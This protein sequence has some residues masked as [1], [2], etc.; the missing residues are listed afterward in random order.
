MRK[1]NNIEARGGMTRGVVT[2]WTRNPLHNKAIG[3]LQGYCLERSL[4]IFTII[5]FI[6][7]L[8]VL[9]PFYIVF[10]LWHKVIAETFT[11][12]LVSS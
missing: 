11:K 9:K 1:L 6:M 8:G 12:I 7:P 5:P 4:V 2:V 10:S 3:L